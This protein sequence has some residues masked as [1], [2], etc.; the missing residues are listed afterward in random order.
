[1]NNRRRRVVCI[2]H[3]I[4]PVL[5]II[6]SYGLL[7]RFDDLGYKPS[8]EE[9]DK[10]FREF[11]YLNDPKYQAG[12]GTFVN[13]IDKTWWGYGYDLWRIALNSFMILLIFTVINYSQF[14]NLN[15]NVY[16]ID[17][18]YGAFIA[19]KK[20]K[21]IYSFLY[22]SLIFFGLSLQINKIKFIK[23]WKSIWLLT[24]FLSKCHWP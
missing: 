8:Y 20:N 11:Q 9:C 2:F 18:I 10:E 13:F 4:R 6:R 22:T 14:H 16:H 1:M 19:T 3:Y 17:E 21:L 23:L 24:Q 15:Q 5:F 12:L 7:K